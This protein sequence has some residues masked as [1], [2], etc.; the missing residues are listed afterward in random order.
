MAIMNDATNQKVRQM[1]DAQLKG[2]VEVLLFHAQE[3]PGDEQF[4]DATREILTDLASLSDGRLSLRDVRI[5]DNSDLA[6]TYGIDKT[7][8]LAFVDGTGRDQGFRFFGA[9]VGYEFMA[10]LDD[11]IDVS[12]GQSRLSEA[13]RAQVK[14]IDQDVLIQVFSTAS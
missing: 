12:Q 1:F 14:A 6:Q 10:L 4:T 3:T 9:P 13:I 11:I 8:A 5:Q 7:P 2:P